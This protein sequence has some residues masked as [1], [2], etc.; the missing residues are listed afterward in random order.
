M[1]QMEK[2]TRRR[3]VI[4]GIMEAHYNIVKTRPSNVNCGCNCNGYKGAIIAN[5]RFFKFLILSSEINYFLNG[6][7]DLL[8]TK[9]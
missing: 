2:Y 5:L 1:K 3:N 9:T 4:L 8:G 6:G 7:A